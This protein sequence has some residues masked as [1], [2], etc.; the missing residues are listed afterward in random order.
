MSPWFVALFA[1]PAVLI[2]LA[3]YA[4]SRRQVRRA[5]WYGLLLITLAFWSLSYAWELSGQDL[6][7]KIL[8]LKVK[9]LGV[10]AL[11]PAW[12]GFI[13]ELVGSG[14]ERVRRFVLPLSIVALSVFAVL[15]TNERHGLFWGA[16]VVE[17]IGDYVVLR[18]RGPG[19]WVNI[20]YTYAVLA[21]GI[22]LL[23][24]HAVHSPY[25]YR[26]RAGIVIAGTVAPWIG[27]AY[28]ILHPAERIFDPTPFLFTCTA[29]IA[30]LAVFRYDVLEPVPT[31]R[32]ARIDWVGDGVIILD[33][34]RRVADLNAAAEA[35]LGTRRLEAAGTVIDNLLPSW[36]SGALPDGP[37]DVTLPERDRQRVFDVRCNPVQSLAGE[38]T[39]AVVILR[40]VT[41]RRAAEV[42]LRESEQ[43]YRAVI[44]QAF[45]AVWL[46]DWAGTIVDANP[47]AGVLLGCSSK[48]L[49]GQKTSHYMST[50]QGPGSRVRELL[51]EAASWETE[52]VGRSGRHVLVA[53]RSKQI[54]SNLVVST[55]RDITAERAQT[56]LRERLLNEAQTA[57]KLKDEFLATVSHELRTPVNAVVGWT[58]MLARR[59]VDDP[60]VAHALAV[61]ERNALAQARLI[62]DL[63][64]LSQLASGGLR[65]LI[66]PSSVAVLIQEAADAVAPSAE[67]K[68]LTMQFAVP[69]DLPDLMVDPDRL[70]QVIV[71]LLT[72]AVKFTPVGGL[73][74]IGASATANDLEV[75]VVDTGIGIALDFLPH[76]FD[77]F[78]QADSGENRKARGLGLGLNIVRRI[79][80][81]HDGR[82]EAESEGPG[83]GSTFR[84]SLPVTRV[85]PAPRDATESDSGLGQLA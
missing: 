23:L 57:N 19:F 70:R 43:R 83:R 38:A 6:A 48:E 45:D 68:Q 28:F 65:L 36:P 62:E 53:G 34:R 22:V 14:R 59:R 16:M 9:Y 10:V 24:L 49:I 17:D 42:A 54:G 8:A 31:L 46:T 20:A 84:L 32:D 27:N 7:T 85:A 29:L 40:D 55:F 58:N 73:I 71:N 79:V 69:S 56:E 33:A 51:S 4:F 61:I 82:I 3:V 12:V 80:E 11:P 47:Q 26:R 25:L 78:R 52:M 2:P 37:M 60:P 72:N 74:T 13:L 21:A 18:G 77:A 75:V 30:A 35:V 50:I 64:D 5:R 41:E 44:E 66:Q 39:G 76:I 67:A 15:W 81:A 1:G 63:L